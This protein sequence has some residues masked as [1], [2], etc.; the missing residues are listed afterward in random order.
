[1]QNAIKYSPIEGTIKVKCAYKP[2]SATSSSLKGH[3][4]TTITDEGKGFHVNK[5]LKKF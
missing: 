2:V 4:V 5:K 1:M 3:L